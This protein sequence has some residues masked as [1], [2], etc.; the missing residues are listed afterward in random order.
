MMPER[1]RW[2]FFIDFIGALV[3]AL[4][5]AIVLPY[6]QSYIGMPTH[7]L[8]LLGACAFTFAVFSGSCY[9]LKPSRWTL[10][11]RTIALGNSGYCLAS[12]VFMVIFWPSL[13]QLGI[14]YFVSEKFIVLTLVSMEWYHAIVSQK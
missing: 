9:F 3:S 2:I 12:M 7:T 1:V 11:L 8:Y 10:A 13:T 14:F 6:F 4:M 5:L